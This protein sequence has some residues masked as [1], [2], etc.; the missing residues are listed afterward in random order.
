M[1]NGGDGWHAAGWTG[2]GRAVALAWRWIRI[3]ALAALAVMV[4]LVGAYWPPSIRE[5]REIESDYIASRQ[6]TDCAIQGLRPLAFNPEFTSEEFNKTLTALMNGAI[7]ESAAVRTRFK[8]RRFS[9]PYQPVKSAAAAVSALLDEQAALYK[10]LIDDPNHSDEA[11]HRF[12]Q[13]YR[14]AERRIVATRRS[15]LLAE[16]KGWARRA[17]CNKEPEPVQLPGP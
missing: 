5:F 8:R 2:A 4:L 16:G 17:V 12:A 6:P 7:R 1:A 11:L 3:G 15:L 13:A 10:A 9:V 14:R